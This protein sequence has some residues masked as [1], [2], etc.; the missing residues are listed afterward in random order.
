MVRDEYARY[1]VTRS[2]H[3]WCA[4]HPPVD[5]S[6]LWVPARDAEAWDGGRW[7][8]M[9][10]TD[11]HTVLPAAHVL[12]VLDTLPRLLAA[13]DEHAS[14]CDGR[15]G[16]QVERRVRPRRALYRASGLLHLVRLS[17]SRE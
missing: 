1:I 3:L 4:P 11:Q 15:R 10:A 8:D 12:Q 9:W 13:P 16:D 17:V 2:D 14:G 7:A 5:A 6:H